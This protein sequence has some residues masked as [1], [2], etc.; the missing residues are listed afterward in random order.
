[1]LGLADR[2]P[3]ALPESSASAVTE[4]ADAVEYE[5]VLGRRQIAGLLFVALVGCVLFSAVAYL[6]G[7]SVAPRAVPAIA[8]KGK[9]A[10]KSSPSS[11]PSLPVPLPVARIVVKPPLFAKPETGKVYLQIGALERGMSTILCEG[12]RSHGF[13]SFVA[14]GP[15]E[16]VYR[17]LIGPLADAAAFNQVE[18]DVKAIDLAHFAR[19]YQE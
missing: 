8:I 1:M 14:P 13:T 6:A 10:F 7:K 18:A 16:N 4:S 17:V 15:S 19:R 9:D 3:L 5:I 12:L 11:V 2:E